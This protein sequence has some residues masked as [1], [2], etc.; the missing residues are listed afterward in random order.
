MPDIA[1]VGPYD[2]T[3]CHFCKKSAKNGVKHIAGFE[4]REKYA[5]VGPWFPACQECAIVPYEQPPQFKK[6]H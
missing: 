2:D 1:Q 6:E 4:R 3:V 5:N